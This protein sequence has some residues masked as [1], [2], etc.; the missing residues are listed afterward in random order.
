MIVKDLDSFL[1]QE[2]LGLFLSNCFNYK[3]HNKINIKPRDD[4]E[5]LVFGIIKQKVTVVYHCLLGTGK[6]LLLTEQKAN[7]FIL[8]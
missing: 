6:I 4:S 3:E 5:F 8:N 1:S 7:S 2:L